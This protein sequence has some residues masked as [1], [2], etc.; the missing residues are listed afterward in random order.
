MNESQ[1][2]PLET[3]AEMWQY[4][5][6]EMQR[7]RKAGDKTGLDAL[8]RNFHENFPQHRSKRIG[9]NTCK[10]WTEVLTKEDLASLIEPKHHNPT[11]TTWL[12]SV[13]PIVLVIG[14]SRRLLDGRHRIKDMLKCQGQALQEVVLIKFLVDLADRT[15]EKR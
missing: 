14:S 11:P 9:P 2:V 10:V 3:E 13:P 4:I 1:K 15:E 5:E 7:H 8:D 6:N 12:G